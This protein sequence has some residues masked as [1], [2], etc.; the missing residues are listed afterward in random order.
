MEIAIAGATWAKPLN[1]TDSAISTETKITLLIQ[2]SRCFNSPTV[3]STTFYEVVLLCLLGLLVKAF[4][5]KLIAWPLKPNL[6]LGSPV[7]WGNKSSAGEA[8]A[9]GATTP[10]SR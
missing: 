6:L 5:K 1:R 2:S 8:G 3:A 7:P 10:E 4:K 9:T